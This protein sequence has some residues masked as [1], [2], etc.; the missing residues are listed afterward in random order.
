MKPP[1]VALT[2]WTSDAII[3][4]FGIGGTRKFT[5]TQF[6]HLIGHIKS[7]FTADFYITIKDESGQEW[8]CATK[9]FVDGKELEETRH[10]LNVRKKANDLVPRVAMQFHSLV[11]IQMW[12][13]G[14]IESQIQA[15]YVPPVDAWMRPIR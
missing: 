6:E 5:R 8:H 15:P 9:T 1:E 4:D 10:V 14:D 7:S 12:A 2:E 11:E 13:R 3:F